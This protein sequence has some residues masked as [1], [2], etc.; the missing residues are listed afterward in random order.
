MRLTVMK[1]LKLILLI[2]LLTSS[3]NSFSD[4]KKLEMF[5]EY[6]R[7]LNTSFDKKDNFEVGSKNEKLSY[8]ELSSEYR[9]YG[10]E[11]LT[12]ISDV[13]SEN[14]EELE[15]FFKLVIGN[16]PSKYGKRYK[17]LKEDKYPQV[18]SE[19]EKIKTLLEN[20]FFYFSECIRLMW[21]YEREQIFVIG[22]EISPDLYAST[23]EW[24]DYEL[25]YWNKYYFDGDYAPHNSTD[26][27]ENG[28]M[29]YSYW[30]YETNLKIRIVYKIEDNEGQYLGEFSVD[31][32]KFDDF[33]SLFNKGT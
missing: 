13:L 24:P 10:N 5:H 32:Y 11:K 30:F 18:H 19:Y 7:L 22:K 1:F 12:F 27:L 29:K 2:V 14:S 25:V 4:E 6:D 33:D 3:C 21:S 26:Q 28:I 15:K 17:L 20:E 9:N 23:A 16:N 8:E 31:F